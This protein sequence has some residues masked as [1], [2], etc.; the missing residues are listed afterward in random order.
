MIPFFK[1]FSLVI[2]I[3][4]RP[5]VSYTKK[6]H[7]GRSK[8]TP[9]LL[10]N[11]FIRLGNSYNHLETYINR[12]FLKIDSPDPLFIKPLSEDVALEK[13]V[14]FF[15]EIIAYSVLLILPISELYLAQ[16]STAKKTEE[17][18]QRLKD[19]ENGIVNLKNEQDSLG[20]KVTTSLEQLNKMMKSQQASNEHLVQQMQV[21]RQELYHYVDQ[22]VEHKFQ[23][24]INTLE[25]FKPNDSAEGST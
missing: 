9:K 13:G 16:T 12:K 17:Q 14:E 4:T 3:F 25:Q 22:L 7:L 11:G 8:T 21:Y 19:I 23:D 18:E 20:S 5:M 6:Y 1:I 10:R 2:R 15:Y 24:K